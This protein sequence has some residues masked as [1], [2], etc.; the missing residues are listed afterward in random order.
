MLLSKIGGEP[1]QLTLVRGTHAAQA[2]P[3]PGN[4]ESYPTAL[5]PAKEVHSKGK[6]S[7]ATAGKPKANV[8]HISDLGPLLPLGEPGEGP[9]VHSIR[10]A[11]NIPDPVAG[12]VPPHLSQWHTTKSRATPGP[13]AHKFYEIRLN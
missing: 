11:D 10:S 3:N 13:L 7:T 8:Q 6:K 2:P 12:L 4:L 1:P 9:H 5:A